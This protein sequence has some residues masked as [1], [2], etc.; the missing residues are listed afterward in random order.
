MWNNL[1]ENKFIMNYS[2]RLV[3][4]EEPNCDIVLEWMFGEGAEMPYH[5]GL[6]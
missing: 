3:S 4:C 1:G 5:I 6:G 2:T